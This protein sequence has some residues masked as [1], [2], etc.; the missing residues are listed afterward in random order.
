M[1]ISFKHIPSEDLKLKAQV[2]LDTVGNVDKNIFIVKFDGIERILGGKTQY[3]VLGSFNSRFVDIEAMNIPLLAVLDQ[4]T[5]MKA[6]ISYLRKNYPIKVFKINGTVLSDRKKIKDMFVSYDSLNVKLIRDVS[7]M[8]G[9]V[10]LWPLEPPPPP[11]S[12][13]KT[14]ITSEDEDDDRNE[15]IPPKKPKQEKDNSNDSNKENCENGK[16]QSEMTVGKVSNKRS[17]CEILQPQ[18]NQKASKKEVLPMKEFILQSSVIDEKPDDT[19]KI[20]GKY[21]MVPELKNTT[22]FEYSYL[23]LY[24]CIHSHMNMY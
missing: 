20:E 4:H 13:N 1:K 23:F 12:K 10:T 7:M 18:S 11:V 9:E 3:F 22:I 19:T 15:Y 6:F 5:V 24:I 2:S 8:T 21:V 16:Q 14:I 17:F